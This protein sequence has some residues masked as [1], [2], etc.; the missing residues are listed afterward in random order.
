MEGKEEGE[1]RE[2]EG[3]EKHGWWVERGGED[4]GRSV[5]LVL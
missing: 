4:S 2:G 3:G 1:E 5:Y